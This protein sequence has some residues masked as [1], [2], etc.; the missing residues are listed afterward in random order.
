M[1]PELRKRCTF[2]N[3]KL[4]RDRVRAKGLTLGGELSFDIDRDRIITLLG[5]EIY[6]EGC[7]FVRELLQN[8]IDAT[9][10]QMVRDRDDDP[11]RHHLPR[12]APWLWPDEFTGR[13]DY[14][15]EVTTATQNDAGIVYVIFSIRDRGTGINPRQIK[16]YFLQVGKS[17]YTTTDFR[18]AYSHHPISRFGIGFLSRLTVADHIFVTTRA[19]DEPAGLS[20]RLNSPSTQF[21]VTKAPQAEPGTTVTLWIDPAKPRPDGWSRPPISNQG[22]PSCRSRRVVW[23][24]ISPLPL[25]DGPSGPRCR[26]L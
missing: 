16:E 17:Y 8:A 25:L 22:R 9:R 2:G 18:K 5:E 26:C 14:A 12:D 1:E 11:G 13:D 10:V 15:I 4:D 24:R 23:A 6:T 20:L 19:R 7:V 21:T 3:L